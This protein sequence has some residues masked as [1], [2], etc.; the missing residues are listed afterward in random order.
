LLLS[1]VRLRGRFPAN[2]ELIGSTLLAHVCAQ[3]R[4]EG[5]LFPDYPQRQPTRFDFRRFE[6]APSPERLAY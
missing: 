1:G 4:I 5:M 3:L 6:S 2:F